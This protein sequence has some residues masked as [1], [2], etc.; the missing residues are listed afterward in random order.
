MMR[1]CSSSRSCARD[2]WATY[3]EWP[4]NMLKSPAYAICTSTSSMGTWSTASFDFGHSCLPKLKGACG[5]PDEM[6]L[7]FCREGGVVATVSNFVEKH[8]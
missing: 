5:L 2:G 1:R 7:R 6:L 8:L 3:G 4:T